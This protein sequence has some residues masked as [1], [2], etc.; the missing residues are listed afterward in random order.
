MLRESS[1]LSFTRETI[2]ATFRRA[3]MWPID[4]SRF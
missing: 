3:G 4:P 1:H 2:R